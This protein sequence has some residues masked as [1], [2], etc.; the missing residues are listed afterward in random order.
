MAT[1]SSSTESVYEYEEESCECEKKVFRS[2]NAL[3]LHKNRYHCVSYR[4]DIID[5]DGNERNIEVHRTNGRLCCPICATSYL[6]S[7]SLKYHLEKRNCY[8]KVDA[9]SESGDDDDALDLDL[10]TVPTTSHPLTIQPAM[11]NTNARCH[12]YDQ[13]I[14][15]A[16]QS[17]D[18]SIDDQMM[19]A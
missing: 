17:M 16:C 4:F 13:A 14:V 11:H 18:A 3:K 19:N 12:N 2:S 1:E 15:Q 5:V 6:S 10:I 9:E 7:S 8:K